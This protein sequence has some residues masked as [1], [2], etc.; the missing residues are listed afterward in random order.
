MARPTAAGASG[1][2]NNVQRDA[3]LHRPAVRQAG[4]LA[5]SALADRGILPEAQGTRGNETSGRLGTFM[6]KRVEERSRQQIWAQ[7]QKEA[8][9]CPLCTGKLDFNPRTGKPYFRCK[10]CRKKV[11]RNQKFLMRE[12]RAAGV[13]A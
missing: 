2:G 10:A 12:R 1:H 13:A 3:F 11:A 7:Q 8:G 5:Q 6:S 4:Y 9:K